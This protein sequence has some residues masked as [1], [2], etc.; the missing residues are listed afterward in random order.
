MSRVRYIAIVYHLLLYLIA[1]CFFG[2]QSGSEEENVSV[3]IKRYDK[4]LASYILHHNPDA[5]H[6]MEHTY[7][8][9]TQTLV[10]NVLSL[11]KM[12]SPHIGERIYQY[13]NNQRVRQTS[14]D[15]LQRFK[16]LDFVEDSLGKAFAKL[17]VL[18]PGFRVP[19]LYTQ[20]S[21]LNQSIVVNDSLVGISLDKYLGE[22]YPLYADY[23]YPNERQTMA[24]SRIVPDVLFFYL[25]SEYSMNY[26]TS[27]FAEKMVNIG[28]IYWIVYKVIGYPSLSETMGFTNENSEWMRN[29]ESKAWFFLVNNNVLRSSSADIHDYMQGDYLKNSFHTNVPSFMPMWMGARLV[30][31]YMSNH[32]NLSFSQLLRIDYKTIFSD[33]GFNI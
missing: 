10:E 24:P 20:I 16:N 32:K 23:Y 14:Q 12:S 4:V 18:L 15:V 11:G 3:H 19:V 31:N 1:G 21:A 6:Q 17:K 28:K 25:C 2:C 5:L 33:N 30:E 8:K 13:Y 26:D 27:L 7:P 22:N 9:E 29:N